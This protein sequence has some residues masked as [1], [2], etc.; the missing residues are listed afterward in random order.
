MSSDVVDALPRSHR[1]TS[2]PL[3]TI[4]DEKRR[5]VGGCREEQ[6]ASKLPGTLHSCLG[7]NRLREDESARGSMTVSRVGATMHAA[8]LIEITLEERSQHFERIVIDDSSSLASCCMHSSVRI[9]QARSLVL[10]RR[11]PSCVH[12]LR[13]LRTT[14]SVSLGLHTSQSQFD[15]ELDG[16]FMQSRQHFESVLRRQRMQRWRCWRVV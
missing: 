8:V 9:R 7:G 11:S 10:C 15:D 4:P 2:W 14:P 3:T 16:N 12:S 13:T 1:V 5:G 6:F